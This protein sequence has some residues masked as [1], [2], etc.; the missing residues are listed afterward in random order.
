[1]TEG[2]IEPLPFIDGITY[3]EGPRWHNGR[4][5]FS[6]GP[7]SQVCSVGETGDFTVEVELDPEDHPPSAS[8]ENMAVQDDWAPE[9]CTLPTA[10]RPHRVAEFDDL[11]TAARRSERQWPT[12]LDLVLP[13]DVE[14][15]ARDLARR[16]SECC[17]FI[18]F[19]F[20]PA[21]DGVVMHIAVAP[22]H[23]EVLDALEA[24]V[25]AK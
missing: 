16:E 2:Q 10:E 8:L 22:D 14:V 4:L 17:A 15:A 19:D 13:R 25:A 12:Q 11:F 6:D 7:A 1:M 24:R 23:V 5:W 18:T 9:A 20:E 3:G 21:V